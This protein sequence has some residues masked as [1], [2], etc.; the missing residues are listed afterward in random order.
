MIQINTPL[1]FTVRRC[2]PEL[3]VPAKPTPREVK[4]LS[5]IDSQ[6]IVRIQFPVVFFYHADPKLGNE[7][8]AS[9]IK[10]ALAKVLVYYYPL[11]GRLKEDQSRKLMVDCTGEGVLFIEAEADVT[12]KEFG[13]FVHPPFPCSEELA[14]D[15]PGSSSI[16]DSPLLLIQVIRLLCGGFIVTTRFNHAIMDASGLVQFM[17][18]L[19]EMAKGASTPSTLPVWQREVLSARDPPRVT[20]THPEYDEL[21]TAE[22]NTGRYSS[23][24]DM[25]QRS[26]FFGPREMLA[27]RRLVPTHLQNSTN[28]EV[29]T[30][31]LWRCRTIA[32]QLNPEEEVRMIYMFNS[33]K[34]KS[35]IPI[36]YYGNA[37]AFP[38]AISTA[39]DICN[40]TLGF[41]LELIVKAKSTV[42]KEYMRSIADLMVIKGRPPLKLSESY[43]VSDVT[44][45]GFDRVD[46]GWGKPA[47]GGTVVGASRIYS[48]YLRSKNHKGESGIVVPICLPEVTMEKFIRELNSMLVQDNNDKEVQELELHTL[49]SKL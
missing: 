35:F 11:A 13:D 14:Y 43:S 44:R 21:A 32:L 40:K 4:H 37:S 8:P 3:I 29:L 25:H 46:F 31:C 38:V 9:V 10:E 1:K 12:L 6:E 49:N 7:N 16:L 24:D 17:T 26:F 22:D 19:S 42:T 5:D 33:R 20:C 18:A 48:I 23:S 39:K 28:F 45:A 34:F 41:S 2:A 36:G 47:Y 27:I 15:V 30:A